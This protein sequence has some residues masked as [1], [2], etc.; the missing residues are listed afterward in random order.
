M[1]SS[2]YLAEKKLNWFRGSAPQFAFP[3]SL[4]NLYVSIHDGSPGANG[5]TADVTAELAGA[6]AQLPSVNLSVPTA[7]PLVGGGFQI[8]NTQDVFITNSASE[9]R[10]LTHFGLWD[11]ALAG[12]F[13]CYGS[14]SQPVS[15]QVADLVRFTIGQL[16]IRE[17]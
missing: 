6:R 3:S 11:A 1:P 14:L 16:I 2:Q 13:L 4:A 5:S 12:N 10:I 15:V 7:S 9:A 17:I 8:S